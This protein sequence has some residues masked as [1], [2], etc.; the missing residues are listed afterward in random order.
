MIRYLYSIRNYFF[1]IPFQYLYPKVSSLALPLVDPESRY[2]LFFTA[3]SGCTFAHKWFFEQVGKLDEALA[4]HGWIHRYRIVKYQK[5]PAYKPILKKAWE[6]RAKNIK[7]VRDP[8]QRAVSSY[9]HCIRYERLHGDIS[10]F[11]NRPIVEVNT[12]SFE[13]FIAFL[14]SVD[15]TKCNPHYRRQTSELEIQGR[16]LFSR[17]IKLENSIQ[18]FTKL[19]RDLGLKQTDLAHLSSSTHHINKESNTGDY[20][21]DKFFHKSDKTINH[22]RDFYNDSTVKKIIQIYDVDFKAYR[23]SKNLG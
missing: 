8:F 3:K 14:E 17:V 18:G 9:L 22:Y 20:C 10:V 12:F 11:L 6:N 21:G 2:I 1:P 5:D 19:E 7:L 15:I 4:Y 23:Y 16:L 13:E